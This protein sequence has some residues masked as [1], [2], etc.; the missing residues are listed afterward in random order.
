MNKAII[1]ART[2]SRAPAVTGSKQGRISAQ[3]E[4]ASAAEA[5]AEAEAVIRA[6]NLRFQL[7]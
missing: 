5:K 7:C 2:D 3:L 6:C 4:A 1:A